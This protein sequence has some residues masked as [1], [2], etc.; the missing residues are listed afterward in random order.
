MIKASAFPAS[1]GVADDTVLRKAR[2]EVVGVLRPIVIRLMTGD[3]LCTRPRIFSIDVT[4]HA[5]RVDV[6]AGQREAGLGMVKLCPLP[7]LSGVA[8]RA[9]SR[10]ISSRV[11]G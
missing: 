9:I 3:A 4:L 8:N 2:R 5:A 10:E 11:I 7:L 6:G 1:G